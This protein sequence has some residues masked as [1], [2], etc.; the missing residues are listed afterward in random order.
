QKNRT[1]KVRIG[2]PIS[3]TEQNEHTTIEEFSEFLRKKTYMLSNAFEQSSKLLDAKKIIP[4]SQ[5]PP[6]EIVKPANHDKIVAEI[7]ELRKGDF[8]LL[9][10]KNYEVFSVNAEK[11]PNILHEIGR[12]REI[13]FREVGEGTNESIDI[14]KYD[15]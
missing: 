8:R 4:K 5:K 12:L 13:T 14:D 3:V 2:K 9:E 15:Q 11:I 6:P 1:I 7:Q 10:S